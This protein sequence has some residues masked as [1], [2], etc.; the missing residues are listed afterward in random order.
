MFRR[1]AKILGDA[2]ICRERRV[3]FGFFVGARHCRARATD[4]SGHGTSV[5]QDM[6][7][8]WNQRVHYGFSQT[9]ARQCRAP[10]TDSSGR[11]IACPDWGIA[12]QLAW[13]DFHNSFV[14]VRISPML[15]SPCDCIR[16]SRSFRR[17]RRFAP[18]QSC[19]C[20]QRNIRL[21]RGIFPPPLFEPPWRDRRKRP[22]PGTDGWR[23]RSPPV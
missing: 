17:N 21:R 15:E 10:T 2:N 19:H 22:F 5:S 9:R 14:Q 20:R 11:V 12:Y 23:R 16:R 18:F 6:Y 1:G 8:V 13:Q 4:S 7:V 3:H